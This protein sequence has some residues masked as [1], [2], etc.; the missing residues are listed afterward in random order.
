MPFGS[1][2]RH[3]SNKPLWLLLL[4]LA[5]Q[6]TVAGTVASLWWWRKEPAP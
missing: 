5:W 4:Y 1:A 3:V 6:S 2:T